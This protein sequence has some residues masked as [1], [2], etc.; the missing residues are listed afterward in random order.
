MY[1]TYGDNPFLPIPSKTKSQTA[2][3]A[4]AG[5]KKILTVYPA[6]LLAAFTGNG[7]F[8]MIVMINMGK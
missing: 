2:A 3:V 5:S 4:S 7:Q 6:S 8:R 1:V